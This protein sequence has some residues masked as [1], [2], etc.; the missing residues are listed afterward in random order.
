M[1]HSP[2]PKSLA[3]MF[4][5]GAFAAGGGVGFAA[6]RAMPP[7]APARS[8]DERS[9]RDIFADELALTPAQRMVIDSAWDWRRERSREVMAVVRPALDSIRD[10]ARV[11]MMSVM[12]STQ[13]DA[14]RRMIERNRRAADS[15]SRA[16]GE[17]R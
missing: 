3:M 5:I 2:R 10:S 11:R 8:A 9:M 1:S 14:F 6:G 15:T 16:R 12:D 4:I 7:A 13:R 17:S